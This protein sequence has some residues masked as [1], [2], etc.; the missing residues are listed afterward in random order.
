M[1]RICL[2]LSIILCGMYTGFAQV[3]H[4]VRST[5]PADT[6]RYLVSKLSQN[7]FISAYGS[8]NW[9]QGS[10]RN[11]AGNYSAVLNG[12]TVGGGVAFGKWITHKIAV[13]L[14]YDVNR[15]HSFID[16]L[17]STDGIAGEGQNY[18]FLYGGNA[19]PPT[20]ANGYC[21]TTFMYHN[22]HGDFMLSPIDLIQNYYN[23]KRVYTPILFVGMG[24]A[25]VSGHTSMIKS[26]IDGKRNFEFSA[27][28]GLINQFKINKYLDITLSFI[29]T[30]QEWHID[31]WYNEYGFQG[32]DPRP[33]VADFNYSARAGLTWYPGGRIYELPYKY[34]Q[35]L[36]ETTE[37]I[38]HIHDTIPC[39]E[40]PIVNISGND[41]VTEILSYPLSIF[42]HL[43]KSDLMSGRDK[44]NLQEIADV[45]KAKRWI[46]HLRG[47]CDSATATAEY[48]KG[49]ALRRCNTIMN[50]LIDMGVPEELI[51]IDPVGGVK[52]LNPTEYDRR[53]LITLGKRIKNN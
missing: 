29:W 22:F 8:T 4:G 51:E 45:V 7:W 19:N 25:C 43:D 1:K 2:I 53:V 35:V 26:I 30:A 31:S 27:D 12:P 9:W 37:I 20:D 23:A 18:Q 3:E 40:Q 38:K 33:R 39:Q 28:L 6:S 16:G 13:R 52:E 36:K 48:N 41:T 46:V 47:S 11:P 44:V 14:A 5:N 17:H 32:G 10:D 34:V 50:I 24:V 49:L 15:S 21:A 42:F